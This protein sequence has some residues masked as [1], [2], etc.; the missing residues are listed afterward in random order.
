[1]VLALLGCLISLKVFGL[2]YFDLHVHT[3]RGSSDSSLSPQELVLEAN[4]I[5][6]DGVL[7]TEHSGGW[8]DEEIENVFCGSSLTIIP[9]L[10][11]NTD[12][13]HVIV[14]GMTSHIDGIHKIEFLRRAV[15]RV[16]GL[17]IAAHPFRNFFDQGPNNSNLL[18]KNMSAQ[19]LSPIDASKH[20]L[21]S[22]VDFIEV[23][24]GSNTDRENE[25]ALSTANCLGKD[26]TGGSDAHSRHGIGKCATQFEREVTDI[27]GLITELK[28]GRFYHS[29]Q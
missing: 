27:S 13:G 8:T 25:F 10:E 9:G 5:G 18:F 3:T 20:P 12:M 15:D 28:L 17:L 24:N 2:F 23:A 7:L 16:G 14:I 11:V 29:A 6:L 4:S 22:Y 26:G 19:N 1:M 21:F